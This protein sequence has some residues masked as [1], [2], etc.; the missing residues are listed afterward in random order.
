MSSPASRPDTSLDHVTDWVFDLDNTLYP[1]TCNLF[2][3]IDLLITQY[4]ID[5]TGLDHDEARALQK[6]YYK[7]NGTTL[8]GLMQNHGVDPEHYLSVVHEI[9][10]SPV[11]AHPELVEQ[12]AALPGRKFI[13]TNADVPHAE[14]V[15][16][17]LGANDLFEGIFD[18]KATGYAPKPLASAYDKFLDHFG[19]DATSAA[20]FDDLE[21]N[22]KVPHD[23]GMRTVQVI[24][25]DGFVHAQVD[26]WEL[27]QAHDHPHIHHVTENLVGFLRAL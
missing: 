17:R 27:V 24:A 19:I 20:M 26:A 22:L 25:E 21:K 16:H 6:L 9:D 2:A 13:F 23:L 15:L 12:I 3:Q 1:R 10:Y 14:K 8:N 4:V 7:D 5:I 11:V 18:I